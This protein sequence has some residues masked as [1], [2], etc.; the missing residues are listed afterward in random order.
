MFPFIL[1]GLFFAA[2]SLFT[3]LLALCTRFGGYISGFLSWLALTF[4]TM[5]VALM[6]YVSALTEQLI[7]MYTNFRLVR[8]MSKVVTTS[9]PTTRPPS[10]VSRLSHS[11]GPP[12]YVCSSPVLCTVSGAQ[13]AAKSPVIVVAR[14]AVAVSSHRLAP[15]VLKARR[16]NAPTR[17]PP[18]LKCKDRYM[19]KVKLK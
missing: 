14:S 19:K 12:P 10:L 18:M 1:I 2:L 3:G 8:P 4:Q 13:S 15:T 7:S 16:T 11:C 5:T 9:R 6:T 17:N